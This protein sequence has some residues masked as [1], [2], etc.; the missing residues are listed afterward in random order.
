[1]KSQTG[2]RWIAINSEKHAEMIDRMIERSDKAEVITAP[3]GTRVR[4][5][6]RVIRRMKAKK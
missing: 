6:N 4:V 1:M 3:Y 5:N 2:A